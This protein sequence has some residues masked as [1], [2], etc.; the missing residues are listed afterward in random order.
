MCECHR[1]GEQYRLRMEAG[2]D[3]LA[4]RRGGASGSRTGDEHLCQM[5]GAEKCR[6]TGEEKST[7]REEQ[8][9][10]AEGRS[11]GEE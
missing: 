8:K 5:E 7:Q 2:L 3:R 9:G 4:R 11:R 10:G 1:R 6:S